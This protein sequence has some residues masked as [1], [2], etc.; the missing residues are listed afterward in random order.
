MTFNWGTKNW[1][2]GNWAT[3]GDKNII[4]AAM[5][6]EMLD[7]D[8]E[9]QL[10]LD[11]KN[12]RDEKALQR[13]TNAYLRLVVSMASKFRHY[14]LPVADLIQEGCIGLMEAADRFEPSREVRF[15]TY[16]NWWVRAAMQDFVL[17]NW[18][19]VRT[20]TTAAHKALF[21][22]FKRM[23][24]KLGLDKDTPLTQQEREK[25]A[26][27]MSVREKDVTLMEGRLSGVDRSLNAPMK[28]DGQQEWQDLL[29][30]PHIGPDEYVMQHMDGE[31]QTR[32]I[33][34]MLRNLSE[35]EVFI[36]RNRQLSDAP[37]T[38][39]A[40]GVKLGISKERVRQIEAQ[41]MQKLKSKIIQ[42]AGLEAMKDFI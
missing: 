5:S 1:V 8:V 6:A 12:K 26:E 37:E 29:A 32:L 25:I 2:T 30:S 15:S 20:G 23:K 39:A 4:K 13:L 28:E 42:Q 31:K 24:M 34:E 33:E 9:L 10:T 19:I 7:R 16:A 41:A 36:I 21:F 22:N 18:S 27:E 14:G 11:W 40:L 38:L 35:R 17:R 3:G